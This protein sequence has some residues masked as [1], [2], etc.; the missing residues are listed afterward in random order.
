MK[1]L[2]EMNE[3]YFRLDLYCLMTPGVSEDIQIFISELSQT[4]FVI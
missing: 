4:N 3:T 1:Q 2:N